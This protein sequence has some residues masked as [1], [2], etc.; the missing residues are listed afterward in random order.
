MA[1]LGT[2]SLTGCNSIPDFIGTGS[3][4]IFTQTAAPTSWTRVTTEILEKK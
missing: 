2:T 1:V 4:T 3:V